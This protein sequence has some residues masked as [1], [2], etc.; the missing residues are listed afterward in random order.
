MLGFDFFAFL[1]PVVFLLFAGLFI[2]MLVKNISE[3]DKNNHSPKLTAPVTVITKRTKVSHHTDVNTHVMHHST[4]YYVTFEM[5]SGDRM[6][7]RVDGRQYGMIVEND[8]GRLTFQGTRF[9]SF[10]RGL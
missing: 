4:T 1:F 9:L 5:E 3:W 6:E 7:L 2:Y 10:E 8:R